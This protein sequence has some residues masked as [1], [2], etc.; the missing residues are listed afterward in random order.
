MLG[1]TIT[2]G[3][4]DCSHQIHE[5]GPFVTPDWGEDAG[6][7]LRRARSRRGGF[8]GTSDTEPFRLVLDKSFRSP[9]EHQVRMKATPPSR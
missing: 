1:E 3:L 5:P 7:S 8:V 9:L 4:A 2:A 6:E